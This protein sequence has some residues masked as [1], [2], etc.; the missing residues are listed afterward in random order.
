MSDPL[1]A[2]RD[3]SH[4]FGGKEV[5]RG[6]SAQLDLRRITFIVGKS[7]EGKS[8]LCRI[9]VGLLTPDRGEVVALGRRLSAASARERFALR[10]ELPYVVQG[11]ALLDWLTLAQ[12]VALAA[13]RGASEEVQRALASV[14]LGALA[15]RLPP[16]VGPG[17]QKLCALARAL[18][19]RPR[20]LVLDEPTTGLDPRGR[21]RVNQVLSTLKGQ[22]LGA[23]VVSHDY[24]SLRL[25]ADEVLMVSDG[26]VGFHGKAA[27]FVGSTLPAV[28]A[29]LQPEEAHARG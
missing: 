15:D 16:T 8:V 6:V 24:A 26:G 1:I 11:P 7:G 25:L 13:G 3:V 4:A 10:R 9:A 17:H 2:L 23:V 12:N 28:R 20:A 22:G 19:L 14:G 27:D 18:A 5:L 29:L 21:A